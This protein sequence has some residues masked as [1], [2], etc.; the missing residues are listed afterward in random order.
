MPDA[1]R[2][3]EGRRRRHRID[4]AI[5]RKCQAL[6]MNSVDIFSGPRWQAD[7]LISALEAN[8]ISYEA[9]HGSQGA[10]GAAEPSVIRVDEQDA[11]A[12]RALDVAETEWRSGDFGD[13]EYSDVPLKLRRKLQKLAPDEGF[14]LLEKY[15]ERHRSHGAGRFLGRLALSHGDFD[16]GR[17]VLTE[18][19]DMWPDDPSLRMWLGLILHEHGS[20][21]EATSIF[22]SLAADHPDSPHGWVGDAL[23]AAS[24]GDVQA[25]DDAIARALGLIDPRQHRVTG[26]RLARLMVSRGFIADAAELYS[27]LAESWDAASILVPHALLVERADPQGAEAILE[28]I[29]SV[30]FEPGV[31]FDEFLAQERKKIEAGIRSSIE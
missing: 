17:R 21:T 14:V 1:A 9:V 10:Y 15:A 11:E 5:P 8:D 27:A 16:T 26:E 25:V 30:W 13:D 24:T 29:R 22:R 18:L 31:E 19:A 6:D 7:V 4:L 20:S 3:T 2:R 23:I 28:E 12:A